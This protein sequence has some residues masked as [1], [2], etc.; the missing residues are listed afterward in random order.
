M[1]VRM[2]SLIVVFFMA[3]IALAAKPAGIQY[4]SPVDNSM[5]NSRTSGI[6]IRPGAKLDKASIDFSGQ[7]VVTGTA[8]N[9]YSGDIVLSSDGKTLIFKPHGQ[10]N[11]GEDVHV[12]FLS[13]VK[14]QSGNSI[15]SFEF[16]FTVTPLKTALDPKDYLSETGSYTY[17]LEDSIAK[18]LQKTAA[19]NISSDWPSEVPKITLTPGTGTPAAGYFFLSPSHFQGTDGYNLIIDNSGNLVYWKKITDGTPVNFTVLPNGYLGYGSMYEFS[20]VTGGGPTKF[21]MMDSSYTIVDSFAMGNGYIAESHEFQLL[22]NGHALML[23]YDLQ[24]VDMSKIVDGGHPGATVMGSIIQEL[25]GDKNVVFQWRSWDYLDLKDSYNDLTL[26]VFDAIH[27][28]SIDMDPDNNLLVS[29]MAFGEIVKINRQTGEIIWI[30]GGRNNQFTFIND[31][32]GS[33]FAPQYFMYQ[34]EVRRIDNGNIL[35]ID[36]GQGKVRQWTR[37]VEYKIDETAKT[38]TKVW[39]YRHNPDL[40]APSMGTAQRLPNGNTLIGW[41]QASASSKTAVTEVDPSGN[42]VLELAFTGSLWASYRACKFD[43]HGGT[44]AAKVLRWELA[45]DNSYTWNDEDGD[46]DTGTT[47]ITMDIKSHNGF[48]YNE[49]WAFRYNYA[50][51]KLEFSGKTP[52]VLPH[53][54]VLRPFN[55]PGLVATF[56]FDAEF[57]KL[58]NPDSIVVYYRRGVGVDSAG[59]EFI[60]WHDEFIA[61][62]TKYNQVT[63]QVYADFTDP[64]ADTTANV[65]CYYEIIFAYSDYAHQTFPPLLVSPSNNA[66]VNISNAVLEWSPVGFAKSY[67]LQVATDAGFSNLVVDKNGLTQAVYTFDA[68]GKDT[69]TYYWRAKTANDAGESE[70]ASAKLFHTRKPY[71][72]V[73][74]PNGGEK[75]K[76]GRENFITWTSITKGD[77]VIELHK[78]DGTFLEVIDTATNSGGY[79]WDV[80]TDLDTTKSYKIVIKDVADESISD[81]SDASFTLTYVGIISMKRGSEAIKTDF[82]LVQS[83]P[84][85]PITKIRYQLAAFSNVEI[86]IYSIHGKK[87]ATLVDKNQSAGSYEIIF[88]ASGLASTVYFVKFRADNNFIQT[89]KLALMK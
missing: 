60:V 40:Y 8:N 13:G 73:T 36:D 47:G 28:N 11:A 55:L 49:I 2:L 45:A 79:T 62:P 14:D 3:T 86:S 67:S 76:W 31:D 32:E 41:G 25:D 1:K 70:W 23:S 37:A 61:L 44:F 46:T 43:W 19:D 30:M 88:N 34:H 48:G 17:R 15:P 66:D 7:I 39:Q 57:Y 18:S 26:K 52:V 75:L 78:G 82:Q 83:R 71:I 87:V 64:G 81:I 27:I 29:I 53:R 80:P 56:K 12:A 69:S 51:L 35:M 6:I 58:P 59:A 24:P 10:Y 38:A 5:L 89:R 72:K 50:P 33:A 20:K 54:I 85:N 74:S 16:Q 68:S 65:A 22:P 77:V 9:R 84:F 21:W 4:V 63:K 42:V